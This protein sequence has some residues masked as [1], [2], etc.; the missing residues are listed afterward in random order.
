MGF[1]FNVV[2]F[3][4]PNRAI[5]TCGVRSGNAGSDRNSH[6]ERWIRRGPSES[7]LALSAT[8]SGDQKQNGYER[9]VRI[10]D[11]AN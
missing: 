6:D 11:A 1:P 8:S 2:R 9:S 3:I 7:Y 4:H 10:S 5:L